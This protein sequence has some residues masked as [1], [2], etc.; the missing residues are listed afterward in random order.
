VVRFTLARSE[1]VELTVYNLLGEKVATLCDRV[2]PAGQQ[3]IR[4][5]GRDHLGR[6]LPS[7]TY[8]YRLRTGE[9][10]REGKMTLLK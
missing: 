10:R 4:W 1:A 3:E 9:L 8:L 5:D 6:D 7:G 2:L